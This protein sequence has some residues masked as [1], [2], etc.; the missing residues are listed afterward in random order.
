MRLMVNFALGDSLSLSL[1]R[2]SSHF[3]PAHMSASTIPFSHLSSSHVSVWL[4]WVSNGVKISRATSSQK[5]Q[6][7]LVLISWLRYSAPWQISNSWT[8]VIYL[9]F[10]YSYKIC[11][12]QKCKQFGCIWIWIKNVNREWSGIRNASWN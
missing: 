5:S 6:R 8:M 11:Q 7:L 10:I 2:S 4:W 1:S 3:G 9:T 12:I